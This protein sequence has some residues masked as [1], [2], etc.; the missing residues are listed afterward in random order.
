MSRAAFFASVVL[1]CLAAPK[2]GFTQPAMTIRVY[3]SAARSPAERA[4]AIRAAAAIFARAG[5][6]TSWRDCSRGGADYPCAGPRQPHDLVVRILTRAAAPDTP[7]SNAVTAAID[8][9][10]LRTE[11][12]GFA[13]VAG[14]GQGGI[15]ATVYAEHVGRVT[16]RTGIAFGLL[17]G[18]AIAH[19]IGH[20][21]SGAD[22]HTAT[23]LMRAVWTDD[24][25]RRDRLEDWTYLV[26]VARTT[27]SR[28]NI[29]D[30]SSGA[31]PGDAPF[32]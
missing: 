18:R 2:E 30:G 9:E 6:N 7:T 14:R 28:G 4:S 25:L 31:S 26:D 12:L 16:A 32:D 20:L 1:V 10:S 15:V 11:R 3:D 5:L 21:L 23:G 29:V 8:A 22:G 19:E 17:L 27:R 24:E 13:A